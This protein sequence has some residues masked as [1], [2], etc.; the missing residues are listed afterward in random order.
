MF[1]YIYQFIDSPPVSSL[2]Y[3]YWLLSGESNAGTVPPTRSGY[4]SMDIPQLHQSWHDHLDNLVALYLQESLLYYDE[5]GNDQ[6]AKLQRPRRGDHAT[7]G[8]LGFML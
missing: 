4:L 7:I 6:R 3:P 2:E 1:V 5:A 8:G